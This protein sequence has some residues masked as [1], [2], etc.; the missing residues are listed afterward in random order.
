MTSYK[1][2]NIVNGVV[3][4]IEKYGIFVKLDNTTNGLIHIS[5]ISESFVKDTND[6]VNIG[7]KIRALILEDKN[8]ESNH[9]KLS[10]KNVDYQI[11]NHKNQKIIETK[12]GFSTLKKNLPV[13]ISAKIREFFDKI[14]KNKK[15]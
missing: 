3:T 15:N 9:V 14:E 11:S 8:T 4:G 1:I 7:D 5:Q 2:G 12:K 10:I 13:W 6:F